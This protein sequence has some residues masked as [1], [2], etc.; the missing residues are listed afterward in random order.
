MTAALAKQTTAALLVFHES[1][2]TKS[3]SQ[4]FAAKGRIGMK[5]P[6]RFG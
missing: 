4:A 2:L 3:T 6:A 1:V 5:N